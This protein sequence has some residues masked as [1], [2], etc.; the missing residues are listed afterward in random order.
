M[1]FTVL[2]I[3]WVWSFLEIPE[4]LGGEVPVSEGKI[5]DLVICCLLLHGLQHIYLSAIK[6]SWNYRL[7]SFEIY[8]LFKFAFV[9]CSSIGECHC[10]WWRPVKAI[11]IVFVVLVKFWYFSVRVLRFAVRAFFIWDWRCFLGTFLT[12]TIFVMCHIFFAIQSHWLHFVLI[13]V[14]ITCCYV[15]IVIVLDLTLYP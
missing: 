13:S 14:I 5:L 2:C 3:R 4:I 8:A 11:F 12:A 15:T 10:S 7:C 1:L 6:S 9:V